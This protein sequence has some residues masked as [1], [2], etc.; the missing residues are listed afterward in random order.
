MPATPELTSEA[1]GPPGS[2]AVPSLSASL[3]AWLPS[4]PASVA[5]P[6]EK[7]DLFELPKGATLDDFLIEASLVSSGVAGTTA[8]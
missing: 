8:G 7:V 6:P 1:A 2:L 4:R 3:S 5:C